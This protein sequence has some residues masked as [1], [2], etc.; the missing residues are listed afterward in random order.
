MSQRWVTSSSVPSCV[1]LMD[2]ELK[3]GTATH[4]ITPT[5]PLPAMRCVGLRPAGCWAAFYCFCLPF[6]F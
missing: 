2:L 5:F 6:F 4:G 1:Q 3:S